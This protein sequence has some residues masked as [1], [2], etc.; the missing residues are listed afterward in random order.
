MGRMGRMGRM[1]GMGHIIHSSHS[2]HS[3]HPAY[4]I[5]G[6]TKKINSVVVVVTEVLLNRLPTSGMLPSNGTCW[7][8]KLLLFWTTPPNTTVPPSGTITVVVASWVSSAGVPLMRGIPGSI[9]LL[10]TSMSMKTLPSA[11]ICGVTVKDK[12]TS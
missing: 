10:V 7:I 11:V 9:V 4:R 3:S 1:G 6:V 2:S 5:F 12:V 8:V